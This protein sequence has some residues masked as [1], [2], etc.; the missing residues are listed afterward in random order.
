MNSYERECL[1]IF[2]KE[3]ERWVGQPYVWGGQGNFSGGI[4]CSGLVVEGL[5]ACGKLEKHEDLTANGL[6]KRYEK[7]QCVNPKMG[8]LAFWFDGARAYH[9][10]VCVGDFHCITADGGRAGMTPDTA[11]KLNAY[12]RYLPLSHRKGQP[13]FVNIFGG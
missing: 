7:W 1:R 10:A 9:V 12:V 6:W 5:I 4:D 13:N 11:Q 8:A 3:V 2:L